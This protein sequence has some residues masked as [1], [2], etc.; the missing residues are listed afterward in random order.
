MKVQRTSERTNKSEQGK[1][2]RELMNGK[3]K[4]NIH[5]THVTVFGM[6]HGIRNQWRLYLFITIIKIGFS[7]G[8]FVSFARGKKSYSH[9][10]KSHTQCKFIYAWLRYSL[11]RKSKSILIKKNTLWTGPT[12][13]WTHGK[14]C[15]KSTPICVCECECGKNVYAMGQRKKNYER[16]ICARAIKTIQTKSTQSELK[17]KNLEN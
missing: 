1:R 7:S 15:T 16:S 9:H 17:W 13:C 3:T 14:V 6:E 12:K 2:E 4:Y 8:A 10:P 5:N 11:I